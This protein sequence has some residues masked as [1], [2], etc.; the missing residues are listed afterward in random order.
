MKY[1]AARLAGLLLLTLATGCT[2]AYSLA[3]EFSQLPPPAEEPYDLAVHWKPTDAEMQLL[4]KRKAAAGDSIEYAVYRDLAAGID[5]VL[6]NCFERIV[7][8]P[9]EADLVFRVTIVTTPSWGNGLIWAPTSFAVTLDTKALDQA[10]EVVWHQSVSGTGAAR[11]GE[12]NG[13]S[14]LAGQRGAVLALG[15]LQR[16]LLEALELR[17]EANSKESLHRPQ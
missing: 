11:F 16:H 9:A 10:G 5:S 13:N 14:S 15:E 17:A 12:L 8:D 7:A 6:G 2:H 4:E 3:P 1:I